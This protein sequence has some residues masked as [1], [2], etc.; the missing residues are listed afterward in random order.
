MASAYKIYIE[1]KDVGTFHYKGY[2][3]AAAEKVTEVLQH[4]LDNW[5]TL[6]FGL[7]HSKWLEQSRR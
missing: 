3:K 5:R 4:N 7:R 6:F 2:N 1:P